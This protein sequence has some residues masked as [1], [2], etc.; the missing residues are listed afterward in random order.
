MVVGDRRRPDTENRYICTSNY[1]RMPVIITRINLFPTFFVF[2][3]FFISVLCV[4]FSRVRLR[5]ICIHKRRE[6]KRNGYAFR[7]WLF[8]PVPVYINIIYGISTVDIILYDDPVV[9]KRI[10]RVSEINDELSSTKLNRYALA[11]CYIDIGIAK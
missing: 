10:F 8:T 7:R 5:Y 4:Q 3:F 6:S 11:P 1:V 2:I 9:N